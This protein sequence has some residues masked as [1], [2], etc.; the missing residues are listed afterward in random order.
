MSPM[1]VVR[2]AARR[3]VTSALVAL[4]VVAL[5]ATIIG[6]VWVVDAIQSSRLRNTIARCEHDNAEHQAIREFVTDVSPR[7]AVKVRAKFPVVADCD[8]Y[9]RELIR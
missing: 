1:R 3:R 5:S 9:A 8:R 4:A 2:L 7:L 6:G